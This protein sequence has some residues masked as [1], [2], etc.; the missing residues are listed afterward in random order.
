[1]NKIILITTIVLLTCLWSNDT[2]NSS[3]NNKIYTVKLNNGDLISG[4]I[5][6]DNDN[7]I[8]I[9]TNYGVIE[10]DKI[11]ITSINEP[12][13]NFNQHKKQ[14]LELNQEGR[15]RT[16]YL[17]MTTANTLYGF[18]IP[19]ILDI[20]DNEPQIAA[21]FQLLTFGGSFYGVYKYTENME[22]PYGRSN[23]QY[24]GAALGGY[25]ILPIMALVGFDNWFD[26]DEDGKITWL[27]EMAAIPYGAVLADKLYHKWELSNG[28]STVVSAAVPLGTFN[29][30]MML[31]TIYNDGWDDENIVRLYIPLIYGGSLAHGY[32]AKNY[33][34]DKSYTEDDG[35]FLQISTGL[36]L[37]NS[38]LFINNVLESD[39][40]TLN[41][42]ILLIGTNGFA[43]LG[44]RINK[45]FDLKRG[46]ARINLLG[47]FAASIIWS[48]ISLIAEIDDQ[49]IWSIGGIASATTGWYFTHKKLTNSSGYSSNIKTNNFLDNLSIT[50][51]IRVHN[52]NIQPTLNINLRF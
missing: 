36:G 12:K 37:Y 10:I 33:V 28:Q 24:A 15:W 8:I 31:N 17:G 52:K 43:Y 44:N 41:R 4:E 42:L 16:I 39:D 26:F 49:T 9:L 47:T 11:N 34:S 19:Y 50:P 23:F 2:D 32:F 18:G 13:A 40:E 46:Q 1:M 3:F 45:N 29:T 48:G 35:Q 22:L 7:N 21:G 51:G 5:I 30:F 14:K 20:W 38:F 25:S 27:Y 6:E